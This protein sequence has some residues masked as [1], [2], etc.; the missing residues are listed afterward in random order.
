[1]SFSPRQIAAH[2]VPGF[3]LLGLIFLDYTQGDKVLAQS[4]QSW[5][6]TILLLAGGAGGFVVGNFLDALRDLSE[7]LWDRLPGCEIKWKF[8]LEGDTE[9]VQRVDD[10]YFTFYV[11]SANLV[12]AILITG[13]VDLSY[14]HHFGCWTW[15]MLGIAA[16]VFLLDAARLRCGLVKISRKLLD[17]ARTQK[18]NEAS[19]A[20]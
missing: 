2:W 14:L 15:W 7:E 17:E 18:Q 8:L 20:S 4:V 10:Y 16:A 12:I 3:M 11:M 5:N 19:S 9:K 1:M 6:I 13:V